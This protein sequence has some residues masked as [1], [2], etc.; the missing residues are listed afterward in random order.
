MT[1]QTRRGV[2]HQYAITARVRGM[3]NSS[4]L[5]LAT[6]DVATEATKGAVRMVVRTDGH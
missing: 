4:E 2:L 1:E 6:N 5:L 3:D